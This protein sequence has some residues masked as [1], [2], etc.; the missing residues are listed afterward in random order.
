[1]QLMDQ[2]GCRVLE[3]TYLSVLEEQEQTVLMVVADWLVE[4][5]QSHPVPVDLPQTAL[6]ALEVQQQFLQEP[7]HRTHQVE[8]LE[9]VVSLT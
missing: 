5:S 8:P 1:M 2:A 3:E 4:Q 9:L 7:G 6:V